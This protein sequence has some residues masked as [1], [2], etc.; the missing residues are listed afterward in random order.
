MANRG[1]GGRLDED[2]LPDLDLEIDHGHDHDLGRLMRRTRDRV[3]ERGRE[4][5]RDSEFDHDVELNRQFNRDLERNR[6]QDQDQE[7]EL[8]LTPVLD[9]EAQ[10]QQDLREVTP[11]VIWTWL[12]IG[13][14][15]AI[16]ASL[17]LV[18][19]VS[20]MAPSAQDLLPW[21]ANFAPYTTSG[22]W[23]RLLTCMFLHFGL[24]HIG[25]NMWILK[26]V[27]PLVER[28]V[29]NTG[30]LI[31]YLGSG[32]VA[33]LAS[34]WWNPEAVSAGA[35]GAIF[36]VIGAL[37]GVL[38]LG[39]GIIPKASLSRLRKVVTTF[40]FYNVYIGLNSPGIDMAAHLGGLGA[41]VLCGMA[42]TRTEMLDAS[43]GREGRNLTAAAVCGLCM[44]WL[45]VVIPDGAGSASKALMEFDEIRNRTDG[46][47][48]AALSE[49]ERREIADEAF[50]QIVDALLPDL[51]GIARGLADLEK[52]DNAK[53]A[54]VRRA[55]EYLSVRIEGWEALVA[56]LRTGEEEQFNIWLD[57]ERDAERLERDLP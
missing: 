9:D 44:M 5:G 54:D 47:Y 4:R 27:G 41:G 26:E 46:I 8:E 31:L 29:G 19:H 57:K 11:S 1:H 12:F 20:F 23:W 7:F 34:T 55:R 45:L 15:I 13:A 3:R 48:T 32:L 56:G 16:F 40:V 17:V 43:E 52:V 18:Y 28:L 2:G 53:V 6:D 10:F 42:M 14:N 22:E 51:Q 39:H 24:L 37:L 35:S 25:F 50:A 21:G 30:F 33:S 36:G 38:I 49:M